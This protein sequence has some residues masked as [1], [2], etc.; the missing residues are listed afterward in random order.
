MTQQSIIFQGQATAALP[1]G[2]TEAEIKEEEDLQLAIALSQSEAEEKEKMKLKNT[3][4]ILSGANK[5]SSINNNISVKAEEKVL[6]AQLVTCIAYARRD[7]FC[8]N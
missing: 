5:S 3:S 1:G 7:M 6:W 4:L 8:F 2:K